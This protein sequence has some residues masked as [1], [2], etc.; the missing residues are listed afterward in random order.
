MSVCTRWTDQWV[1]E[2][3]AWT[4]NI[5]I[6][7]LDYANT[8]SSQCTSY[9]DAGYSACSKY[10]DDGYSSCSSW[11]D[12]G[13][14]NCCDWA[15]CSWFC[16]AFYWVANWICQGWIWIS[17]WVCKAWYW[18]ANIVCQA[19]TWVVKAVCYV[20]TYLVSIIC[21]VL[22][23]VIRSV[24]VAWG[25]VVCLVNG[26]NRGNDNRFKHVFVLMLENRSFDH[27]LGFS[28]ITG[29]DP[30]GNFTTIEG[31]TPN[32]FFN[33]N[34][35]NTATIFAGTPADFKLPSDAA[36]TDAKGDPGHEFGDTVEE[37]CGAG[38]TYTPGVYP[39]INMSGFVANRTKHH[40]ANP[41]KAMNCYTTDQVPVISQLAKEFVVCD[42]FYSSL[43]GPTWPNRFFMHA[44]TSGGLDDSPSTFTS[45]TSE[46]LDG[47][48]F[49]QGSFYDMLD[50]KCVPWKIYRGDALPQVL[51]VAG[52]TTNLLGGK[53]K[54]Y[55][56]FES[57][58]KESDF[59]PAY[60]FIEPH[61]GNIL[62]GTAGDFTCGNS[63]HPLDD[64]TRGEKLIKKTYEAIRNSPHWNNS[65]LI[66]TY[67]EHGGFCDHVTPP[68][69]VAPG[70]T[71]TDPGNNK[72]G[73]DFTQLGVRVPCVIVSPSVPK[74]LIDHREYHSG[75]ILATIEE[76]FGLPALTQ[77]DQKAR[78]FSDLFSLAVPRTDTP[79][80]L[81]EA[82]D[83]GFTCE[84]DSDDDSPVASNRSPLKQV[85]NDGPEEIRQSVRPLLRGF[86]HI[87][88]LREYHSRLFNKDKVVREYLGIRSNYDA[89]MFINRVKNKYE[90]K[91]WLIR[92]RKGIRR[93]LR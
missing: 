63:Q 33:T 55:D 11:A 30:A 53:I 32:S 59:D 65:V 51:A 81:V 67:D 52:M 28:G 69:G 71:I 24:C 73:F 89:K 92:R 85:P 46:L 72:H 44:A 35:V 61:Y 82:A 88:F 1:L 87:A 12:E 80:Q 20:F 48:R 25:S 47:F 38:V 2:C 49:Q 27:M 84:D 19:W 54:S 45:V 10:E 22:S 90:A 16:D 42:H 91:D 66:I 36:D 41:E 78:K 57:D 77:R 4:T 74:N 17:S 86:M 5:R 7:C 15:P 18:V 76:K 21:S 23:W 75:S 6:Q 13:H 40:S 43:P 39:P 64:V 70:D 50:D 14:N 60:I 3:I 26:P 83:S 68:A 31:L 62:P 8:V 9:R 37:I 29:T 34:P 56:D 93:I 58:V 79:A